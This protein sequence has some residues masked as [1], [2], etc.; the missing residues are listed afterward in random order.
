VSAV[1][2]DVNLLLAAAWD[3]HPRHAEARAWL[4]GLEGFSTCP[5][6]ELGFIRVSMSPA[7]G[8]S[9]DQ[10]TA[11]ISGLQGLP[12]AS[13][14]DDDFNAALIPR[15]A[16]YKDTTDAY[17]LSL[18][19]SHRQRLATLDQGILK[20]EWARDGAFDPFQTS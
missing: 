9:F 6:T 2:L 15:V 8:A 11:F 18:A 19:I 17:L 4:T 7:F 16:R 10:A 5:L 12:T 13:R 14:I 20:A 3:A 1:L